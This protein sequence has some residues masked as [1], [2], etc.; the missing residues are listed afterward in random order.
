M[1]EPRI[2]VDFN[3]MV[4]HNEVL[5]SQGDRKIDS[6]GN[7]VQFIEG[8]QISVY[9]ADEDEVGKTD[10]LIANGIAQRSR[11]GSW[12]SAA[13]WIL[14]IDGDGIRHESEGL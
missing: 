14:V 1:K 8:M 7:E 9:M 12:T 5:L 13:R 4:S 6:A 10:N 2:C 11:N 3:E